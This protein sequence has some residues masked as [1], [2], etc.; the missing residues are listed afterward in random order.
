MGSFM[1]K[2]ILPSII[3]GSLFAIG[4]GLP[5]AAQTAPRAWVSGHGSDTNGCGAP[6]SPCR[7]LQ[8]AHDYAVVD[9]GEI[10]ILDPAGYGSIIIG[11]AIS[12]INDGVGTAGVQQPTSGGTAIRIN[13]FSSSSVTLRGLD[14]EGLGVAET[15]I[16]MT[17]G[18]SLTVVN[19]VVRHFASRGIYVDTTS[20]PT[21]VSISNS[22]VSD[23]TEEGILLEPNGTA[24]LTGIVSQT[25]VANNGNGGIKVLNG[26]NGASVSIV[27]SVAFNNASGSAG[28]SAVSS[29]AALFLGGSTASGN[30]YG[31]DAAGGGIAYSY[32][33]NN[34][35]GNKTAPVNGSLT[36]ITTQ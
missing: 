11:K 14:I 33:T 5:A 18:G 22:I 8:Y 23:N 7:S 15:G 12:I 28:F 6:T 24:T 1:T 31:V 30:Q 35:N 9:G 19:C 3:I 26:G 34:L 16:W 25:T 17:Y 27:N 20:G 10:D 13:A 36:P 21:A 32:G 2:L 29:G 4:L